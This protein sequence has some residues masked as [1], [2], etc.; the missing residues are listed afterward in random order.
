MEK[1][2]G[3][4]VERYTLMTCQWIGTIQGIDNRQLRASHAMRQPY[5]RA[6][7]IFAEKV[8]HT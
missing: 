6:S 2:R 8:D 3:W 1:R 5:N 7:H 4:K